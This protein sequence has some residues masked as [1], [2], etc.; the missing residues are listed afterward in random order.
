MGRKIFMESGHMD[1]QF[2][3]ELSDQEEDISSMEDNEEEPDEEEPDEEEPDEEEPDEEE[4]DE[5]EPDEEGEE[6]EE[7]E[8][9]ISEVDSNKSEGSSSS[10][11]AYSLEPDQLSSVDSRGQNIVTT[12]KDKKVATKDAPVKSQDF[13]T[14]IH[15]ILDH[16]KF[17]EVMESGFQWK[18]KY[19]AQLHNVNFVLF[20]PFIKGDTQEHD[21]HCGRYLSR[22]MKVAHICRYCHCPTTQADTATQ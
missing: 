15:N 18:L 9:E 3:K 5:E 21:K 12:V 10:A 17:L 16:S 14:Q 1:T 2:Q 11:A 19:K 7:Q 4:P 13:H 6:E 8:V 20:C 22:T